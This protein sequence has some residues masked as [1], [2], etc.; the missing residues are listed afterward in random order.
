MIQYGLLPSR[1]ME[2]PFAPYPTS[3]TPWL[4]N[5]LPHIRGHD[6]PPMYVCMNT[7]FNPTAK[8]IWKRINTFSTQTLGQTDLRAVVGIKPIISE[9][10]LV[11]RGN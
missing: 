10:Y 5:F 6:T 2:N 3:R 4:R 11:M 1:R 7:A 9:N 8:M